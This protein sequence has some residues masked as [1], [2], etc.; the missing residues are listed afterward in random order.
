M[1]P[2]TR[3][4]HH[5][6]ECHYWQR[7]LRQVEMGIR[8]LEDLLVGSSARAALFNVQRS[9]LRVITKHQREG[10]EALREARG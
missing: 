10:N 4:R 8:V 1:T 3:V 6:N 9:L 7:Q 5:A 2:E